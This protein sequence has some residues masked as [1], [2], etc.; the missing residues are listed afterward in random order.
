M[1]F[2]RRLKP[3]AR[4]DLIPMIDVVFQLVVFFMITSTFIQAPGISI[5]LPEARTAEPVVMTKLIVT[6]SSNQEI[7]LN[8]QRYTLEGLHKAL[9]LLEREG[10]DAVKVVVIEADR[11]VSYELMVEVLDALRLNGFK[12]VNLRMRED[13]G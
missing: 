6:I 4:V 13:R 1:H 12:G 5:Q 9:S 10:K 11:T 7:Y 8:D 3:T 2:N